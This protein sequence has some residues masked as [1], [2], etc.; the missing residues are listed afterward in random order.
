MMSREILADIDF[1]LFSSYIWKFF[2]CCFCFKRIFMI[3]FHVMLISRK[4]K[5]QW[6]NIRIKD[7][8]ALFFFVI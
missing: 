3:E 1:V 7:F 5:T 4:T 2:Q 6:D 8:K